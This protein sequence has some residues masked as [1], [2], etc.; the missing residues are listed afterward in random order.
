MKSSTWTNC[1]LSIRYRSGSPLLCIRPSSPAPTVLTAARAV[2]GVVWRVDSEPR[3]V[4]TAPTMTW[5]VIRDQCSVLRSW[6][7]IEYFVRCV[8]TSRYRPSGRP[9]G[10][11]Y[12]QRGWTT[13]CSSPSRMAPRPWATRAHSV[14]ERKRC[15]TDGLGPGVGSSPSGNFGW[16]AF[17]GVGWGWFH[18]FDGGMGC[19]S[20]L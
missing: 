15:W 2:M 14:G 17:S 7:P 16:G 9:L 13:W 5:R 18:G 6:K 11:Q 12:Q 3:A 10:G 20:E 4:S 1:A 8:T 19:F